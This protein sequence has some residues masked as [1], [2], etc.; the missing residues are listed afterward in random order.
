MKNGIKT[1][2][3]IRPD[4][5]GRGYGKLKWWLRRLFGRRY[6]VKFDRVS[7]P[8]IKNPPDLSVDQVRADILSKPLRKEDD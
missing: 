5:R 1:E 6:V 2:D 8:V 4:P 3:Y 7:W